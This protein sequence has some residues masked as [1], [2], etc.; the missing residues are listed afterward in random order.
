MTYNSIQIPSKT[1]ARGLLLNSL[2]GN[3]NLATPLPRGLA[4]HPRRAFKASGFLKPNPLESKN[5]P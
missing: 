5:N 2:V 3:L 4:R 1:L